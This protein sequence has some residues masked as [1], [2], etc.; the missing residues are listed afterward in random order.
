MLTV[1]LN[2]LGTVNFAKQFS[3]FFSRR[4]CTVTILVFANTQKV[5]KIT[6]TI[7]AS[8]NKKQLRFLLIRS[9]L[10]ERKTANDIKF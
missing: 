7:F 4:A 8:R 3:S 6:T 2:K 5:Q 9:E 10:L 1:Q